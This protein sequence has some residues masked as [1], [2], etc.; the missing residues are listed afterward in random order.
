M[1]VLKYLKRSLVNSVCT[2]Y[3]QKMAIT[4][5]VECQKCDSN[6]FLMTSCG[7][8]CS[9]VLAVGF[10]NAYVSLRRALFALPWQPSSDTVNQQVRRGWFMNL[11][12]G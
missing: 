12:F 11:G 1:Q 6:L 3:V 7:I 4:P 9:S 5:T 2:S 8:S 10:C